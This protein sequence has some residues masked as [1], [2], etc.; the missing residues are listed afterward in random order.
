MENTS[1]S[2]LQQLLGSFPSMD[3]NGDKKQDGGE[4]SDGEY[5]IYEQDDDENYLDDDDD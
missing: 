4:S 2:Y 3:T 1:T 5:Q